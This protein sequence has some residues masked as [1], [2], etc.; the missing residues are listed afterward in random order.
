MGPLIVKHW[1]L[2]GLAGVA[3]VAATGVII[4]R[5]E[6]RRQ[7]FTADEVRARL[8]Q[9]YEAADP[10]A[11]IAAPAAVTTAALAPNERHRF[12]QGL[13]RKRITPS[14]KGPDG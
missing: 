2:F 9:R 3:G 10:G 4:V 13:R 5:A 8:H 1:K 7:A 11:T 12:W 6:R 14:R